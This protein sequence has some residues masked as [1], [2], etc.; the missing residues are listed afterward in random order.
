MQRRGTL[1]LICSVVLAALSAST[2]V[3]ITKD[4]YVT[5]ANG[6]CRKANIELKAKAADYEKSVT[7]DVDRKAKGK[8]GG[9]K[10]ARPKDVET[11]VVKVAT[12]VL[13]KELAALK[14]LGSPDTGGKEIS[15]AVDAF[16]AALAEV[17]KN[18][19]EAAYSDPFRS[20][21]KLFEALG[22]TDCGA[23]SIPD[24]TAK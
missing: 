24:A 8:S 18:P 6:V 4:A 19:R 21:H 23:S 15:G 7:A 11:F 20:V 2:A 5:Q 22:V 14:A 9:R 17:T 10:V 1:V 13:T 16:A 12:P 3:A